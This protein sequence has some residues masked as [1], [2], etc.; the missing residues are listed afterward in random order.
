M[1]APKSKGGKDF[2]IT[3]AGSYL[4]VCYT[5]VDL[6]TH[7]DTFQGT[8]RDRRLLLITFE[9]PG[10]RIE[11]EQEDGTKIDKPRAISIK[12]TFSMHE[13]SNL[14]KKMES[15]RGAPFTELQAIDFDFKLLLGVNA[16]IQ[17][18][19]QTTK[20]GK[21]T[22]AF[23]QSITKPLME[24]DKIK[25]EN[26]HLYFEFGPPYVTPQGF[27]FPE[28]MPEWIV[29]KIKESREYKDLSDMQHAE[30]EEPVNPEELATRDAQAEAM[31]EE[32]EA[33]PF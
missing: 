25:S 20:D 4:A 2:P 8:E 16:L 23:I 3:K 21:K 19:H 15:W 11:I 28:N 14:R 13:K 10:E 27:M 31:K 5:V 30:L 6:G 1:K 22:Y 12:D 7:E 29:N 9:I 26:E 32:Q 24:M 33:L 17:V 18:A